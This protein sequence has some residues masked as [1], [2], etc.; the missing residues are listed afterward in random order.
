MQAYIGLN[1][2]QGM[3][4][5]PLPEKGQKTQTCLQA[6]GS[7]YS[8]TGAIVKADVFQDHAPEQVEAGTAYCQGGAAFF[9]Q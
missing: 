2:P 8:S 5:N 3:K 6:T 7:Q 1:E 9:G 4:L